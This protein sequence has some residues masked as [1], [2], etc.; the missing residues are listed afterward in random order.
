ML[1]FENIN[2]FPWNLIYGTLQLDKFHATLHNPLA[3]VGSTGSTVQFSLIRGFCESRG[4]TV[5][6]NV[7]VVHESLLLSI[8]TI[9]VII[10]SF[11]RYVFATTHWSLSSKPL[12]L[13]FPILLVSINISAPS[14]N[15]CMMIG[16]PEYWYT[17]GGLHR[18]IP[19]PSPTAWSK[20]K[21][22]MRVSSQVTRDACDCPPLN[23]NVAVFLLCIA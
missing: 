17:M 8:L 18:L 21:K 16:W 19:G 12:F 10:A 3:K 7:T 20:H 14:Q 6:F 15:L 11:F 4:T 13:W 1:C 5:H 23:R 9:L 22:T 2:S